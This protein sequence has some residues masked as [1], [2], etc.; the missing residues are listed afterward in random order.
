MRSHQWIVLGACFGALGCTA[1]RVKSAQMQPVQAA[2]TSCAT[3]PSADSTIYDTTQVSEKPVPRIV[4]TIEYPPEARKQRIQGRAVVT[5][6]VGPD[7]NVE[8]SS[9]A[10]VMSANV[11][12]DAEARR[13]VSL[14]TF[15]PGCHD[16]AA[17]RTRIAVPFDFTV[18]GNTAGV[19][20]G[21]LVGVWAGVMG[22]MMQ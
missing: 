6:I 7:G 17:V 9:V 5:A 12:L 21:V 2:P 16:G 20:F 14:A 18:T 10:M 8:D 11:L 19:A 15:W 13:V 3:V 22:A 1:S 4:P